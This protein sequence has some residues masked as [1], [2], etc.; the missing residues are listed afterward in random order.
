MSKAERKRLAKL[1]KDGGVAAVSAAAAEKEAAKASSSSSSSSSSSGSSEASFRD[2]SNYIGMQ[3]A[4]AATEQGYAV[5]KSHS[6]LEDAMLDL[7]PDSS[8]DLYK[9]QRKVLHWDRK[10]KKYI[11]LGM[12]EIDGVTGRRKKTDHGAGGPKKKKVTLQKQYDKWADKSKRKIARA[13][14]PEE[15]SSKGDF[16]VRADWRNGYQSANKKTISHGI[17]HTYQESARSMRQQVKAEALRSKGGL[18]RHGKDDKGPRAEL[19]T[20]VDIRRIQKRKEKRQMAARGIR[21]HKKL[22]P[23]QARP[24]KQKI[25]FKNLYGT[26][27]GT[28]GKGKKK[29]RP[30]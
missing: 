28:G 15:N 20:E 22:K 19:R 26:A 27:S 10:K 5:T 13:G 11:K 3:P 17:K 24:S 7:N 14:A 23:N 4:D 29:K 18:S 30:W 25:Q 8:E 6:T 9:Q 21:P 12:N 16:E 2:D 1:K